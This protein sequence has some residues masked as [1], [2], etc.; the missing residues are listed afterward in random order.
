MKPIYEIISDGCFTDGVG[1]HRP[2]DD[3]PYTLDR[4]VLYQ[5]QVIINQGNII[6]LGDYTNEIII[7]EA[8]EE[9]YFFNFAKMPNRKYYVVFRALE[10]T[11]IKF[12]KHIIFNG[13]LKTITTDIKV[14]K[15]EE[16]VIEV[17][18]ARESGK[19]LVLVNIN[20]YDSYGRILDDKTI[21]DLRDAVTELENKVEDID[22]IVDDTKNILE[23]ITGLEDLSD[24]VGKIEK[25]SGKIENNSSRID[26]VSGKLETIESDSADLTEVN[27]RIDAISGK[28]ETIESNPGGGGSS[29]DLTEINNRIDEIS[30]KLET[31]EGGS[32]DL[33]GI[34][35]R[36]DAISGD[37]INIWTEINNIEEFDPTEINNRISLISGALEP[38]REN[39]QIYRNELT[40][41][42]DILIGISGSGAALYI[43]KAGLYFNEIDDDHKVK[44][45][46]T[47][48]D[49]GEW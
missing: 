3:Y 17:I 7:V 27:N 46:Q 23:S 9:E 25:L 45:G 32:V 47:S 44:I 43:T 29:T 13:E 14:R 31:L 22:T 20:G 11:N 48:D 19:T 30:G 34:T 2:K 36:I 37:I 21:T 41:S 38:I 42:N 6:C 1:P 26:S 49:D 39:V 33:T 24:F 18:C 28:L 4:K 16:L 12:P 35:A 8:T 40:E 5:Q 15:D 10:A